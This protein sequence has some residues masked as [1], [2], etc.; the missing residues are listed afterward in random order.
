LFQAISCKKKKKRIPY[1]K[2]MGEKVLSKNEMLLIKSLVKFSE[3]SKINLNKIIKTN[4]DF[5]IIIALKKIKNWPVD[6]LFSIILNIL[7]NKNLSSLVKVKSLKMGWEFEKNL[8]ENSKPW[9]QLVYLTFYSLKTHSDIVFNEA[10]KKLDDIKL[11]K[12]H[13]IEL[14]KIINKSDSSRIPKLLLLLCKDNIYKTDLSIIR[15]NRK[16]INEAEYLCNKKIKR[17]IKL[18]FIY[19]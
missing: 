15:K 18:R 8:E 14:G 11:N 3:K 5:A 7:K 10:L 17:G 1:D 13:H 2:N 6:K 19:E 4:N 16:N 9:K 12:Q